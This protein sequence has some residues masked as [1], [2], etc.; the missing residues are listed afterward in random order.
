MDIMQEHLSI[1][2]ECLRLEGD[3]GVSQLMGVRPVDQDAGEPGM[4]TDESAIMNTARALTAALAKFSTPSHA[5]D[6][7]RDRVTE[8]IGLARLQDDA[9]NLSYFATGSGE[10]GTGSGTGPVPARPWPRPPQ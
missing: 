1:L 5:F 8:A 7:S 6:E 2:S 3:E 4:A 9:G 10:T